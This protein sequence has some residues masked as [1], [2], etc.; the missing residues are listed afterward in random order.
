MITERER[1]QKIR[2]IKEIID[3]N[4]RS[5]AEG[6]ELRHT[7]DLENP[8][9]VI[10][11]KKNNFFMKELGEEF[12][13]YS[14]FVRSF[15]STF[16]R[17]IENIGNSIAK[18]TY[19]VTNSINSYLLPQQSQHI[20]YIISEYERHTKPQVSDYSVFTCLHPRD[21]TS[22]LMTHVTDHYF[23]KE[24]TGEH[25]ILELKLGGDLDNKKSKVEKRELLQE[26]FLLKNHLGEDA[27]IKILLA[28]AYNS[29]GEGNEWKQYTVK[30]YFSEDELLIG[31]EYWNFV[32][33]EPNGFETVLE[34]YKV[35]AQFIKEGIS[36]IKNLYFQNQ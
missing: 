26:Y 28:T 24:D 12:M 16:G 14:A 6:F 33:D 13:F 23:Y 27:N 2:G 1:Q 10:N 18:L 29:F 25:F 4:I 9:G 3:S 35:S 21:I 17:V 8:K 34:Q 30:Q 20:D 31:K 32:C 11:S 15:D 22:Y 5:F 36:R 7:S 19:E